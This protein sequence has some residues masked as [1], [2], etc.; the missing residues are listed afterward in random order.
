M[1]VASSWLASLLTNFFFQIKNRRHSLQGSSW[2]NTQKAHFFTSVNAMISLFPIFS[3]FCI[4]VSTLTEILCQK[5]K[6]GSSLFRPF[7][8]FQATVSLLA[9]VDNLNASITKA[10]H[11]DVQEFFTRSKERLCGWLA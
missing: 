2:T 5:R 4:N 6:T 3:L 9:M 8:R 11:A 7:L 10:F 1:K